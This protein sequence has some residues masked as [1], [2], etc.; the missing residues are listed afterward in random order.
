MAD[1]PDRLFVLFIH[2]NLRRDRDWTLRGTRIHLESKA[3]SRLARD[4][5]DLLPLLEKGPEGWH[6]FAFLF[7]DPGWQDLLHSTPLDAAALGAALSD[8]QR[9]LRKLVE[10][11]P[12]RLV[13]AFRLLDLL[14]ILADTG[15]SGPD[16]ETYLIG[17]GGRMR[18]DSSKVI[19]AVIRIANFSRHVPILR[20]DDDVI[21]PRIDDRALRRAK[22]KRSR[23]G[24]MKLCRRFD[25]L[26]AN[27]EINYFVFSGSY[28]SPRTTRHFATAPPQSGSATEREV[29]IGEALNGF[30]TRVLQ[31]AEVPDVER[32][33]HVDPGAGAPAVAD[34]LRAVPW[35]ELD[36][37]KARRFLADLWRI[38]AN[39]FRQVISGAGLCLSD[40]AILDLPPFSNMQKNVMWIDDHLKFSLHHE[41]GHFG[42]PKTVAAVA[43]SGTGIGRHSTAWFRQERH[44]DGI[45]LA[46]VRWHTRQY[47]PRLL[48]GAVADAWLREEPRLKSSA[49]DVS[50]RTWLRIIKSAPG[51]YARHFNA[52]I[53]GAPT[54]PHIRQR[55]EEL[56]RSRLQKAVELWSVKAYEGTFLHLV[57]TGGHDGRTTRWRELGF[58]PTEIPDGLAA[59]VDSL[60]GGSPLDPLVEELIDDFLGYADQV[61]FW[62]SFVQSTRFLLNEQ[63]DVFWPVPVPYHRQRERLGL[64][65]RRRAKR[66]RSPR[67]S[68]P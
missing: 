44:P 32:V 3:K 35:S 14:K 48:R 5:E 38:G 62:K 2:Y 33:D 68:R 9:R 21:F 31:L 47:L 25:E 24:V 65:R 19:E 15:A 41:L 36:P 12:V 6:G 51:R 29:P 61:L 67:R 56:A 7:L 50:D 16:L 39:P 59:A 30:A 34:A 54:D 13:S 37:D 17:P 26:S 53:R 27:A 64:G 22:M 66:A 52:A 10:R 42:L 45:T 60:G 1:A 58:F 20:F 57:T 63:P 11:R 4:I 49:A 23:H 43:Q 8:F 28:L 40:G 55:L 46:D 18:Y